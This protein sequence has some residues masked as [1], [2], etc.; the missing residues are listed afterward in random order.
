MCD[1]VQEITGLFLLRFLLGFDDL[2][3]LDGAYLD[4]FIGDGCNDLAL[5]LSVRSGGRGGLSLLI[6]ALRTECNQRAGCNWRS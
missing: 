6:F 1:F 2:G 5:A 4:R 3:A